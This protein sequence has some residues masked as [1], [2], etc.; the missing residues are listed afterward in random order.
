MSD[1]KMTKSLMT[2]ALTWFKIKTH[3]YDKL[4]GI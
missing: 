4:R 1:R 3:T 2:N